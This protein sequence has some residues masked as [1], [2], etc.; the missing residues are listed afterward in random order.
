MYDDVLR[1]KFS[2]AELSVCEVLMTLRVVGELE[3]MFQTISRAIVVSF[4]TETRSV[5][6]V[7]IAV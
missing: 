1:L 7:H 6:G 3:S 2:I 5:A 4:F